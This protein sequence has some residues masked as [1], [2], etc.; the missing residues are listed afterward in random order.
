MDR[1]KLKTKKKMQTNE[2]H[3][4]VRKTKS[5]KNNSQNIIPSNIYNHVDVVDTH[6]QHIN[7]RQ[8]H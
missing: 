3:H 6:G 5:K 8:G 1:N 4:L 2:S 7:L